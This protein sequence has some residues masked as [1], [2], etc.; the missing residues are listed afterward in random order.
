MAADRDY[1][2]GMR[3]HHAGAVTMARD[4]LADP[5]ARSPVLRQLAPAIVANQAFEITLLDMVER[6]LQEPPRGFLGGP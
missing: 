1:V 4:Y 5:E 6:Q 3:P 2:R